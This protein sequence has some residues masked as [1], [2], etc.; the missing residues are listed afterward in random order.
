MR[1]TWRTGAC[2]SRHTPSLLLPFL[3]PP[4]QC[5]VCFLLLA[6]PSGARG[7]YLWLWSSVDGASPAGTAGVT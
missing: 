7:L 5:L 3:Q 1:G 4:V 6:S 2:S